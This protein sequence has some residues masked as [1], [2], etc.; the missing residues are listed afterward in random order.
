MSGLLFRFCFLCNTQC[1]ARSYQHGA[2]IRLNQERTVK[3]LT[4]LLFS[5]L[6]CREATKYREQVIF[7]LVVLYLFVN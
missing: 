7:K 4:L 2:K 3:R 5:L 1:R 6:D